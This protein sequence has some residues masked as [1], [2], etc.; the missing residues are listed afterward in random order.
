PQR[1]VEGPFHVIVVVE[2]PLTDRVARRKTN[3]F[4]IWINTEQVVFE[5]FPTFF[6]VLASGRVAEITDPAT[7]AIK[8]LL[9]EAQAR[10]AARAGWWN[11]VVFGQALV[12]LMTERGLFG[13][14]ESGVRFLSN[15]AFI[16]QL[17][18]P[19]DIANGP[20]ITRTYVFRD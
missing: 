16:A 8:D 7:L 15:T 19:H 2:G 20:F 4:G 18:V 6:K 12:R 3:V 5:A 13:I 1:H 14:N 10:R 9:P 17:T 11:S